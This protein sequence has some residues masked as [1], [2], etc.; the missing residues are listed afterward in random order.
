MLLKKLNKLYDTSVPLMISLGVSN[1]NICDLTCAIQ[2]GDAVAAASAVRKFAKSM[3]HV[4][5][6]VENYCDAAGEFI[7]KEDALSEFFE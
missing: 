5:D 2:N 1:K 3:E 6:C 4:A 7:E